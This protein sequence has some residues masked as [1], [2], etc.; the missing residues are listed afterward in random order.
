[1]SRAARACAS[2]CCTF[3]PLRNRP[4]ETSRSSLRSS[5]TCR[6]AGV[7]TAMAVVA[8]GAA[9]AAIDPQRAMSQYIRDR[10]GSDNGFPGG[11]VYAI[12]QTAD[13]YLWI[14]AEKGLVRF[15]GLTFRLFQPP[16]LVSGVDSTV[17]ALVP[18]PDGGLWA[19]LRS[20]AV[21]R[22][23]DEAFED[24]ANL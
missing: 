14:G 22:Y 23:R 16:G 15:D 10:W 17:L 21:V 7:L 2:T 9:P 24:M 12:T 20:A 8:F 18:D 6:S 1:R 11:P 5:T 3:A 13:G 4:P 19:Q